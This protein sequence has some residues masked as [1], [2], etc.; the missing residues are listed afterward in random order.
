MYIKKR[1]QQ[2]FDSSFTARIRSTVDMEY[3]EN[4]QKK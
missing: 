3:Q 2:K 1:D 4:L